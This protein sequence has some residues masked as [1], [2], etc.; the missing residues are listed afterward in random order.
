[1]VI[2]L[3]KFLLLACPSEEEAIAAGEQ[4]ASNKI[5]G[6]T[7][8]K[9]RWSYCFHPFYLRASIMAEKNSKPQAFHMQKQR[10]AFY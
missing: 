7:A 5:D 8:N 6:Y 2:L 9:K 10:I 4:L 1:L 3:I